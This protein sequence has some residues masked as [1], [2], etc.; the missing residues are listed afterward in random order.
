MHI[1]LI[2][3]ALLALSSPVHAQFAEPAPSLIQ[4]PAASSAPIP[5]TPLPSAGAWQQDGL[6][7]WLAWGLGGAAGGALM[8][9][10]SYGM[11]GH[12]KRPARLSC[13]GVQPDSWCSVAQWHSFSGS[14]GRTRG[15]GA[16]AYAY[17]SRSPAPRSA[18]GL[19]RGGPP[20]GNRGPCPF[21]LLSVSLAHNSPECVG[22]WGV[23]TIG[24]QNYWRCEACGAIG[25][26][27]N[28]NHETAIREN[29]A[30]STLDQL[31]REGRELLEGA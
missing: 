23:R 24:G 4:A 28:A 11:G 19:H 29:L 8:T 12:S 6:P 20:G 9:A 5:L 15:R 25:Y 21:L 13:S 16:K 18:V 2:L 31:T 7:D 22:R 30:G 1:L 14:A 17:E 27:I 10:L 26:M 3:A